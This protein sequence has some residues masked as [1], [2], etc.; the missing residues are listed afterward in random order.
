MLKLSKNFNVA[1][2]KNPAIIPIVV[3]K[4][5]AHTPY[6]LILAYVPSANASGLAHAKQPVYLESPL[7]GFQYEGAVAWVRYIAQ[8]PDLA[9]CQSGLPEGWSE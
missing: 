4:L 3:G 6:L 1:C 9:P 2:D 5:A 7:P 8:I